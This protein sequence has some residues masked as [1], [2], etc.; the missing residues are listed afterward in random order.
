MIIPRGTR[1]TVV[2]V[3]WFARIYFHLA[4]RGADCKCSG[5]RGRVVKQKL[6]LNIIIHENV[7]ESIPTGLTR[8]NVETKS[9]EKRFLIFVKSFHNSKNN[10]NVLK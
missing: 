2:A 3:N 10:E 7:K 1:I 5:L 8:S 4:N 6:D 9:H